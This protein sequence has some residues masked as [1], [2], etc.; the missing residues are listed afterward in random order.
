[1]SAARR[2][3]QAVE[4]EPPV[5][6]RRL[7]AAGGVTSARLIRAAC[8]ALGQRPVAGL[9][10]AIVND[11]Q[12][13]RLHEEYMGDSRPT[14]VLAFDL[15]DDLQSERI[16]GQIVVSADTARRE[17]ERRGLDQSE[18]LARYVIHGVLHLL[19]MDDQTPADRQ[20]MRREENRILKEL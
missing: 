14:D 8:R 1:M 10:I 16:E 3:S 15:R 11:R 2:S 6:V 7:A 18:E 13:G 19:G 12:I 4:P 9:N 5:T 17:A 20:R